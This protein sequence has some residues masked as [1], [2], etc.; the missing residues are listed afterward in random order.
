METFPTGELKPHDVVL[1]VCTFH[2]YFIFPKDGV[3]VEASD[4]DGEACAAF[5]RRMQYQEEHA[6]VSGKR[7]WRAHFELDSISL[8]LSAPA[9]MTRARDTMGGFDF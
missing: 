8:L 7:Y 3:K 5:R 9:G 2:R 4:D 1:A 6:G